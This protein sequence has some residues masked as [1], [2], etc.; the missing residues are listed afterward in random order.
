[1]LSEALFHARV[2]LENAV[3]KHA[4]S[5]PRS[6]LYRLTGGSPESSGARTLN[7]EMQVIAFSERQMRPLHTYPRQEMRERYEYVS[8]MM[9]PLTP[10]P[11][12]TIRRRM[13]LES[14]AGGKRELGIR[15]YTPVRGPFPKPVLVFFHGGG[16]CIGSTQ[17]HEPFCMHLADLANVVVVSVDYR[18]SPEHPFPLPAE[19]AIDSW[20]WVLDNID[21][22][23]GRAD[24]VL[25]GGDSA[26]GN[27]AAIVCQQAIVRGYTPPHGQVL[28]YPATDLRRYHASHGEMGKG[29]VLTSDLIDW[30]VRSYLGDMNNANNALASPLLAAPDILRQLPPAA[31]TTCGFDPLRDEGADYAQ[32]MAAQ[33]VPVDYH[34]F[35][36]LLHGFIG[37]MGVSG[38]AL[39]G[40]NEIG[41]QIRDL[42]ARLEG[43]QN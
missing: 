31:V 28:I 21:S 37:M 36:D 17:T 34:E 5:L 39:A 14:D 26:G 35:P 38:Q 33:G 10:P 11:V 7:A 27:L 22:L 29:Y 24:R 20:N 9:S 43:I 3:V 4:N 2:R 1:M 25:V 41:K 15:V 8:R 13:A 12:M 6:L 23:A 40:G 42:L 16:W 30:F 19:D 18:L 32:A